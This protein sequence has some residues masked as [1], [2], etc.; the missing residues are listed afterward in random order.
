M[1]NFGENRYTQFSSVPVRFGYRQNLIGYNAFKWERK[2][3]PLRYEKAKKELVYNMEGVSEQAVTYFFD[4]ALAQAE[5]RL[6]QDNVESCDTMYVIGQRRHKIAS[7]SSADLLTLELDKVNARN[8]LENSRIALKRAMFSLAS[9]LGMDKNTEIEI[10][11]PEKPDAGDIPADLALSLAKANSP[12]LLG[13]RQTILEDKRELSRAKTEALFNASVNASVGFNQVADKFAD[14]YL[15]PLRQDIVSL[16]VTFPLVD[17]GV[18]KGK[19]NMALNNLN[20]STLAAKQDELQVEEDILMTLSDYSVR[21]R[22]I[23]SASEAMRLADLAYEQTMQRFLIGKAD[24]N[25]ITLSLN[26]KQEASKNYISALR[27]FWQ[28]HFKIRKLTLYDFSTG[29]SLCDEIE[30][31]LRIE[32]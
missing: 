25:S 29:R 22:L 11:M 14:A 17:W 15:N 2:I 28:S 5:F 30:N 16:Q 6:A 10:E 13:H 18:R 19:V 27:N 24:L 20:V 23:T 32:N 9:F 21:Q 7:I 8:T 26:R 1:R 4:L 12:T 3:E 31:K